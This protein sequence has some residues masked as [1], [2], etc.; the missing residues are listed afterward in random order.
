[1]KKRVLFSVMCFLLCS[2]VIAFAAVNLEAIQVPFRIFVNYQEKE[3][4][5]SVVVIN[6]RTYIPLR[7]SAEILNARVTWYDDAKMIFVEPFYN[8]LN[9]YEQNNRWGYKNADGEVVIP[10]QYYYANEFS[11]GLAAVRTSGGS[12]M[13][14]G[15]INSKGDVVIPCEYYSASDFH[16]GVAAVSILENPH[17]PKYFYI[18][19]QGEKLY[20][21]T[22]NMADSFHD[23][24]ALVLKEGSVD[25]LVPSQYRGQKW[26]YININGEYATEETFDDAERFNGNYAAVKKDGKWGLINKN[27]Q[28]VVDYRYE[29][30]SDL[31]GEN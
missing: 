17:E 5:N 11:E 28:L 30:L 26:S 27:F 25:P 18:N 14:Y 3:F 31:E 19:K 15:Y 22:F 7:E 16:N 21:K 4:E 8:N 13:N 24:Y 9:V 20:N 29:N 6:D 10:A 12:D 23:G 2:T 1:L